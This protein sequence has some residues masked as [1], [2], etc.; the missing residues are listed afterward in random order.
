MH[1]PLYSSAKKHG[2][3]P[4][5]AALLE[6]LFTRYRVQ[7]VFAGHDH[8][9]ERTKLQKGIQHFITGAGGMMRR[10]D[11]DLKSPIRAASYDADNSFMVVEVDENEISFK[12]VSE[13]GDVVDSGVI[14][15]STS[16]GVSVR[17]A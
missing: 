12:S 7:V 2:S 5:L 9:Y 17:A 15:Q 1:H 14:K 10:G 4:K 13:K 11:I 8:V 6:P 3:D 16:V